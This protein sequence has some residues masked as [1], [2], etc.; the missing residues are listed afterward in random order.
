MKKLLLLAAAALAVACAPKA[1]VTV[2]NTLDFDR[3]TELVEIPLA[4]LDK[5]PIGM[6]QTWVV[7]DSTGT[8]VPSQATYDGLL[9][10]QSGLTGP[11][12]ARFTV[13]AGLP[14]TFEART[15][16]RL[17]PE[18]YDDLVW[19][20]DRVAFRLYGAAL[21]PIDGPSGGIDALYKRA[22][23]LVTARWYADELERD[24]SYHD[25][26]G[27]GLDDYKVGPT[28][29]AGA[30]APWVDGALVRGGNHTGREILDRGP[31][32]TTFRLTYPDLTLGGAPVSETRTITLDAGAQL[33][34]VAQEYGGAEPIQVAVGYP[35]HADTVKYSTSAN[36]LLVGEPATAKAS[37]V[38]LGAVLP[39]AF[40]EAFENEYQVP[41]GQKGAGT[42]RHILALQNYTPGEPL[43]YYTGFGW[44]RSGGWTARRF[45]EYLDHFAAALE[46]PLTITIE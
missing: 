44:E 41:E 7:T 22:D 13:T 10:F 26:H 3:S 37:G 20:N 29:G 19:E 25:D 27:T 36:R 21:V 40:G 23:T 35:L 28:L 8:V 39:R 1:T 46:T 16:A 18:R 24:L 38:Y 17:A 30:A 15:D 5:I 4:A 11:G 43:V 31:L 9:V 33:T 12:T 2:E 32:R 34:R 6:D 14:Q 45:A 42:Y